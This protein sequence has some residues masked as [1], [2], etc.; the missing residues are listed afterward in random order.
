MEEEKA[1]K[2]EWISIL[3]ELVKNS[4]KRKSKEANIGVKQQ[5]IP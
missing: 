1:I 2:P 5:N 3:E 4:R